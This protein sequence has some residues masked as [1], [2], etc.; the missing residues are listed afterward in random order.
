MTRSIEWI[1]TEERM[2]AQADGD[3]QGCV[4]AYHE[5]QGVLVMGWHRV[6]DNRF[7]KAWARTPDG[8]YA[9]R[10]GGGAENGT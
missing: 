5:Y 3:S 7:V 4:L 10:H 6:R 9:D 1:P 8:P 2:P